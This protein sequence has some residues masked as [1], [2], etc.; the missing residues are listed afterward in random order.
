[1]HRRVLAVLGLLPAI[2]ALPTLDL[3]AA[4][5]LDAAPHPVTG[6]VRELPV[7]GVDASA[8]QALTAA[9]TATGTA[10]GTTAGAAA[11]LRSALRP[12]PPVA[13]SAA[14]VT[15]RFDLV[16]L[17][18]DGALATGT[19][20]SVRVRE[21][22]R[23]SGWHGLQPEEHGPDPGE[24]GTGRA[25]PAST[26]GS[27][28]SAS[29]LLATSG[30]DG[31]QVRVDA[32]GGTAPAALRAVLVDGGRSAADAPSGPPASAAAATRAPNVI[33][34][35]Q[36]GADE[37]LVKAPLTVD[38]TVRTLYVHHTDTTNSYTAAQAYAQVRSVY[39][40]H[41]RSRGW[42]DIGYNF[43]IDRF[44]RIYE[45]RRGSITQAVQGAHTGGFNNEAI[46][47]SVLGTF[48]TVSPTSAAT[49]AVVD[50]AAWKSAQY[51]LDPR[52]TSR[53]T[54]T[55][56][57]TSRFPAGKQVLVRNLSGH[58]DV[59]LTE[60]PGND[61]Y[62][63][64]PAIR[65]AV[66]GRMVPA[67]VGASLSSTAVAYSG[68]AVGVSASV[69]TTQKWTFAV[70][71]I[72]ARSAVNVQTGITSSRLGAVWN[73][74][75][76]GGN[77]ARPG[78]YRVSVVSNSPVGRVSFAQD[79]EIL[80][81]L[82]GPDGVCRVARAG[83][84]DVYSSAVRAGRV[85][86]PSA[87]TV[88]LTGSA[89][90]DGL[91]AAPLAAAKG[92]PL[93]LS[94]QRSLPAVVAADLAARG[95]VRTAYIVG[96]TASVSAGVETQLRRLGVTTVVRLTGR[97]RYALAAAVARH[98]GSPSR[99]AVVVSGTSVADA[100]AAA[101][102]AA[103]TGRPLLLTTPTG[104]PASTAAALKALRINRALLVGTTARLSGSVGTQLRAQGVTKQSRVGAADRAA[105]AA[106]V[107]TAFAAPVG[108]D[109]VVAVPSGA[110]LW[111]VVG[112]GQARLTL[113]ADAATVPAATSAWLRARRPGA[114]H[115][116]ADRPTVGTPVLRSLLV[117]LA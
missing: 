83:L 84:A 70:T 92:A 34:R 20:L 19:T 111:A 51:F 80:P 43:L 15:S 11:G 6:S 49:R 54:S 108:T 112:A 74:R 88:V 1:M 33:T 23:W 113:L 39:L 86:Y 81:T 47:I 10:T 101:G 114:V 55:G 90:M 102:P 59:G 64:L 32:S 76:T 99:A 109:Q 52:A 72:C 71:P 63:S 37:S 16:A 28:R 5:H 60:C 29:S 93:L 48:S 107:A 97:D 104:V 7:T 82:D 117:S 116:M 56:G 106:A 57:G 53:V 77:P 36:W 42:N 50:V 2:I 73:L 18:W 8:W 100:A 31:I 24:E 44:G 115:L 25:G 62:P 4:V 78:V 3:T 40:F 9:G 17:T 12:T 14:R 38:P 89:V 68:P 103:A 69:P 85:R 94:G 66:A 58:R 30:A 46:G 22:G 67:L 105:T 65:G 98:V 96:G 110:G 35:R 79:L 95:S 26:A 45:G 21:G 41:T 91:V 27:T 75:D 61:F 13:L 87:S